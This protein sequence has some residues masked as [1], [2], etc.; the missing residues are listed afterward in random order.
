MPAA[1]SHSSS[2]AIAQNRTSRAYRIRTRFVHIFLIRFRTREK[3]V[4]AL[5]LAP[6]AIEVDGG[7]L[8]SP[9]T[10]RSTQTG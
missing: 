10:P 4:D 5:L 1:R 3:N 8:R 2:A 6:D 9:K 7:D